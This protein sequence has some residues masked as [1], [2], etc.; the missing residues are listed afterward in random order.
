MSGSATQRSGVASVVPARAASTTPASPSGGNAY[1]RRM[2]RDLPA[3]D[4]PCARSRSPAAGRSPTRQRAGAGPRP[5]RP[6]GRLRRAARRAGRL[7]RPGG[8][9]AARAPAAHR[10][11]RAPSARRRDGDRPGAR[12]AAGRPGAGDPARGDRG[13]ATSQWAAPASSRPARAGGV[14][15][16][17]P[18]SPGT[19]PAPLGARQRRRTA[20]ALRRLGHAAQ[21]PGPARRRRSPRSRTCP[22]HASWSARCDRDPEYVAAV[23]RADRPARARGPGALRRPAHGRRSTRLRTPRPTCRAASRAE[24]YGMVVTEALARGIPVLAAAV[25]GVPETARPDR[26]GRCPASWCPRTTPPRSP[27]R[28]AAGSASRT[29]GAPAA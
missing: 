27:R 1:D 25:D 5:R 24:T 10:G 23:A 3:R 7:R 14:A 15:G 26:T 13:V 20:A 9:R 17:T 8:R 18:A 19:D 4:G 12:R 21:G 6:A 29:C 16:S 11:A 22:G 28:C 2:C